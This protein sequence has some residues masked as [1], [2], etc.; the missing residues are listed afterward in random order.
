MGGFEPPLVLWKSTV[1]TPTLHRNVMIGGSL[2]YVLFSLCQYMVLYCRQ[3]E[4]GFEPCMDA[5]K[6]A[7]IIC[8]VYAFISKIFLS[9]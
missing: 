8:L 6:F 2:F 5:M 1:I 9:W 4:C 7:H 3:G